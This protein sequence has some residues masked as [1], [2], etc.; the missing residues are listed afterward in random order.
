M[1]AYDCGKNDVYG[2]QGEGGAMLP[3]QPLSCHQ[4]IKSIGRYL[5][6]REA[7]EADPANS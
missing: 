4:G 6:P 7:R 1:Q 3:G 5:G 2:I